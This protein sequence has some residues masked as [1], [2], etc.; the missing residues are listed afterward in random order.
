M[1]IP[2]ISDA[3]LQEAGSKPRVQR[4]GRF[5]TLGRRISVKVN[6]FNVI[7]TLMHAHHWDVTI[8]LAPRGRP[9]APPPPKRRSGIPQKP[10]DA[11]TCRL[12]S[13]IDGGDTH[14]AL[15]CAADLY[16]LSQRLDMLRANAKA[17]C[18][19]AWKVLP[20]IA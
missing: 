8:Q 17:C 20:S 3:T 5:G 15:E 11:V 7:C 6:Y 12:A 10:L 18:T 1:L 16:S 9:D 19:S 2:H 14:A 4:N 13:H